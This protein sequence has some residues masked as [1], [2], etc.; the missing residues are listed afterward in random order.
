MSFNIPCLIVATFSFHDRTMQS[1][2]QLMQSFPNILRNGQVKLLTEQR[3][4]FTE[5][6]L[7]EIKLNIISFLRGTIVFNS[8]LVA[9]VYP[10]MSFL[11]FSDEPVGN[12]KCK[13]Q[14]SSHSNYNNSFLP[15]IW[16]MFRLSRK[17][18]PSDVLLM[19]FQTSQGWR[20]TGAERWRPMVKWSLF[21][22]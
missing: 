2:I 3:M 14:C 10:C 9:Y 12:T 5:S 8:R 16:G 6:G 18:V 7:N 13:L 19:D 20:G 15:P 11:R 1:F 4:Y 22:W 17:H 21:V